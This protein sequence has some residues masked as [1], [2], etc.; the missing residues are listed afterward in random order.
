VAEPDNADAPAGEISAVEP[1]P[2]AGPDRRLDPACGERAWIARTAEGNREADDVRGALADHRHVLGAGADVLGGDVAAPE[3][4]DDVAQVEHQPATA[5][6]GEL[7]VGTEHG[8]AAAKVE[9]RG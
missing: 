5:V 2:A 6:V 7:S 8:L 3:G 9:S 4:L 1:P